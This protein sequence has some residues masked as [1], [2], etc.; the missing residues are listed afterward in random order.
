MYE[1]CSASESGC[2]TF[3]TTVSEGDDKKQNEAIEEDEAE[4]EAL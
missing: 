1:T 2:I 3:A 4:E